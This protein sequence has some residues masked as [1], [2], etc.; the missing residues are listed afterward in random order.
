MSAAQQLVC[1]MKSQVCSTTACVC[2][3]EPN[4]DAGL[5][6]SHQQHCLAR[7]HLCGRCVWLLQMGQHTRGS[8]ASSV[9]RVLHRV[10]HLGTR[11]VRC[12]ERVPLLSPAISLGVEDVHVWNWLHQQLFAHI[13]MCAN[14][15]EQ[16]WL[17]QT[18]ATVKK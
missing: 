6:H 4:P 10:F 12:V 7:G 17:K 8:F 9:R 2:C 1:V 14:G 13:P 3:A 11:L 15:V 18:V 16:I 5:A